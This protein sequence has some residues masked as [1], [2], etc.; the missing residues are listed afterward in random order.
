MITKVDGR[1]LLR[2]FGLVAFVRSKAPGDVIKVTV[3]KQ[4]GGNTRTV[5]IKVGTRD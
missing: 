2:V 1:A 3:E 4:G 5:D